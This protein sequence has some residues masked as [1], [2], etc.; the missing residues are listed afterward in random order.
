MKIVMFFILLSSSNFLLSQSLEPI[1]IID[2]VKI[3]NANT[4]EAKHFYEQNWKQFRIAAQEEGYIKSY[5]MIDLSDKEEQSGDFD[6]VL[7][8]EF[9]DG[10]QLKNVEENFQR[11]MKRVRPDGPSFLNDKR[12]A[13]F[14]ESVMAFRASAIENNT[15]QEEV[16]KVVKNIISFSKYYTS[17]NYDALANAYSGDGVI[18][19]PGADI[20][21]G[22]EAIKKRWILPEG[23]KVPYHK[24]K[25]IEIKII[26]DFAYDI[27]YYEGRTIRKNGSEVS[28]KGKYLIVWKKEDGDWKIYADAWNRTD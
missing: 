4:K 28:W 5:R 19:P 9:R 6:L 2:F 23:V 24:I 20:I 25:P 27:G 14:R 10:T 13:D 26:N 11:V 3:K 17:Q 21:K 1:S 16:F 22:R 7:V 18:L 12:P 15:F 8:T